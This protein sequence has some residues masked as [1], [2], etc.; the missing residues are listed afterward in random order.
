MAI[1]SLKSALCWLFTR[2]DRCKFTN[3]FLNRCRNDP[4]VGHGSFDRKTWLYRWLSDAKNYRTWFDIG[5]RMLDNSAINWPRFGCQ[6]K[7]RKERCIWRFLLEWALYDYTVRGSP[8]NWKWNICTA[9]SLS[10]TI[11]QI[12]PGFLL[13]WFGRNCGKGYLINA[14]Y[15]QIQSQNWWS[16]RV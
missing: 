8:N 6:S 14:I 7:I 3:W 10:A 2:I 15:A 5:A 11:W 12:R 16:L 13:F 9:F 1:C 4:K